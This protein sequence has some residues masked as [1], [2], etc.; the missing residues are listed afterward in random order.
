MHLD[1]VIYLLNR[2]VLSPYAIVYAINKFV[3]RVDCIVFGVLREGGVASIACNHAKNIFKKVIDVLTD[4]NDYDRE[5]EEVEKILHEHQECL[6]NDE[7]YRK[8]EEKSSQR[9]YEK[10]KPIFEKQ[11][12]KRKKKN[13]RK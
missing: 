13:E 7:E 5:K 9:V 1:K 4:K 11:I 3:E 6:A 2:K 12:T 8:A 10:V